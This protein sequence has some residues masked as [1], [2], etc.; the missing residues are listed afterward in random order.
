MWVQSTCDMHVCAWQV[1]VEFLVMDRRTFVTD[2][3]HALK[4]LFGENGSN[5]ASYKVAVATLCSR[6]AGVF[7]SLKVRS[8][9]QGCNLCPL[10][11]CRDP[12]V[13][14]HSHL[15]CGLF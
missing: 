12:G 6:L 11:L 1:N 8:P 2:E 9:A 4:A 7:A 3:R 5:S 14:T 10:H 15:I 13:W